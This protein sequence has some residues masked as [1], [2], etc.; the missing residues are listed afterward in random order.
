MLKKIFCNK[1]FSGIVWTFIV[2][3]LFMGFSDLGVTLM[4]TKVSWYI[5]SSV[6]RILNLRLFQVLVLFFMLHFLF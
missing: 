4:P 3:A 6:L 5:Y 2:G 1:R